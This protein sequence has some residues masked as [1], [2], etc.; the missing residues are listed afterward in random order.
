MRW[1]APGDCEHYKGRAITGAR[2]DVDVEHME[3]PVLGI[4]AGSFPLVVN[5]V[6]CFFQVLRW[7]QTRG[8]PN[9]V[10]IS[11]GSLIFGRMGGGAGGLGSE[12]E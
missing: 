8:W 9:Y 7:W 2:L 10:E 12:P 4:S 11:I 5:V 3:M 1:T 6:T